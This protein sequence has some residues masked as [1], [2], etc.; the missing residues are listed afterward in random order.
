MGLCRALM[1]IFEN[2]SFEF[3]APARHISFVWPRYEWY[4]RILWFC[5]CHRLRLW[6][7]R[8]RR[9]KSDK[10]IALNALCARLT[11]TWNQIY[12]LFSF[13]CFFLFIFISCVLNFIFIFNLISPSIARS[14]ALNRP[15]RCGAV[16]FVF[17]NLSHIK[18]VTLKYTSKGLAV[19]VC[20]CVC[21]MVCR[22]T[23]A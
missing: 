14:P 9:R 8:Q 7:Q 22:C 10:L 6:L 15:F 1:T 12:R 2:L 21:V 5:R 4:V 13:G 3:R 23:R 20:V 11:E 18:S 16:R 17:V 19:C